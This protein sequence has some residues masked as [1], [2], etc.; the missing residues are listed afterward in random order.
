MKYEGYE[1]LSNEFDEVPVTWLPAL[2]VK[3]IEISYKKNVWL[4]GG[5]SKTVKRVEERLGKEAL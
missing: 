5:V 4:P 3:L 2:L 1:D